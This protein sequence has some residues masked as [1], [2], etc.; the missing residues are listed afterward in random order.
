MSPLPRLA[1]SRTL[2]REQIG[3]LD[4]RELLL[5]LQ[6]SDEVALDELV[7]RKMA[8]LV[9][10]AYRIL[11]DREEARDVVQ[12]AFVRIWEHRRRYHPRYSANT[13]IYRIATNLAI[14]HLRSRRS[15]ERVAEPLRLHLERRQ[16]ASG[17][18]ALSELG[19]REVAGIFDQLAAGLTERQRAIFVMRELEGMS[20]AEV[21]EIVGCRE[22]TVRNHLFNARRVLRVALRERYP[23][24]APAGHETTEAVP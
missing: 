23:E 4:D 22:S 11:G 2:H 1:Y 20:S 19:E 15:R 3:Q 7:R 12:I 10:V 21:A 6:D 18:R 13:W 14:D 8:P 16:D 24:Y 5:R 9:Q 17:S